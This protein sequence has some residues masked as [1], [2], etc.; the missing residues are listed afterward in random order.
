MKFLFSILPL[1][2]F[3]NL[4]AQVENNSKFYD[5][6][7][8]TN[9]P[10]FA[11]DNINVVDKYNFKPI[12]SKKNKSKFSTF[13][14][15]NFT[16]GTINY[17]VPNEAT[18]FLNNYKQRNTGELTR[19]KSTGAFYLNNM[20]SILQQQ[21]IPRE[22]VY[23]AVI[24]THLNV[25]LVSWAGAAGMWQFMPETGR[26]YGLYINNGIDERFDWYKSTIAAAAYLQSLYT[27]FND[28]LLVVAAYNCGGGRVSS[29]IKRS[30]SHNFWDLQYYLPIESSN[31]VKKFIGTHQIMQD[32]NSLINYTPSTETKKYFN[33]LAK[34]AVALDTVKNVMIEQAIEGKYNSLIIA[35]YTLTDITTFN[36]L[37][38]SFDALI[39]QN[40]SAYN[41]RLPQDKM[42]LFTANKLQIMN[43]SLQLYLT[44][45][46]VTLPSVELKTIKKRKGSKSLPTP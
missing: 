46:N 8:I 28:W 17:T 42:L 38:P 13:T 15:Y 37:N 36:I 3:T 24:E 14:A 41:L 2:I 11:N 19:M 30:G 7:P 4:L 9:E 39:A 21:G 35:K 33:P 20:Q 32:N 22:L 1:F 5:S 16:N 45:N 18:A 23:L 25:N 27:Q 6:F 12:F 43:E 44:L 26:S 29:A 40:S 34:G 10:L 31:H